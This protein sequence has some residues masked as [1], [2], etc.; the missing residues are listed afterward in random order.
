MRLRFS[1]IVALALVASVA[2]P[3]AARAQD[4]LDDRYK[5]TSEVLGAGDYKVAFGVEGHPDLVVAIAKYDDASSTFMKEKLAKEKADLETLERAHVYVTKVVAVGTI[6][7]KAAIVMKRYA[8]GTKAPDW[9][10]SR[11]SLLNETS[12]L[13]L[14]KIERALLASGLE[15]QDLQ[16][17]VDPEGHVVVAD[18][19]AVG[20][21][22]ASP[23]DVK[24]VI[25]AHIREAEAAIAW[26]KLE[27]RLRQMPGADDERFRDLFA[28]RDLTPAWGD[29]A[30]NARITAALL[31]W[32]EH[33][34]TTDEA[35]A[36]VAAI[37]SGK[38]KLVH[39]GRWEGFAPDEIHFPILGSFA[40]LAASLVKH[41]RDFLWG[42]GDKRAAA[43]LE[44]KN[45]PEELRKP[46]DRGFERGP[47]ATEGT[48]G[49]LDRLVE[50]RTA[51]AKDGER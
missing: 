15:I 29:Q 33:G 36:V 38:V 46:F 21:H 10:E 42:D 14:K 18:P 6:G 34:E 23:S 4:A 49:A 44:K 39:E 25:D 45:A 20:E 24:H 32:L 43:L 47:S 40:E 31:D 30:A 8:S 50:E 1:H 12:V 41:V 22:V 13:E 7:G 28:K 17:L 11:W 9:S 3:A 51:A 35:R 27:A 26:R 16:F 48:T 37:R 2:A 5:P 19:E